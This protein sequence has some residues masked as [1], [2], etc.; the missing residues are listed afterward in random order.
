[1]LILFYI[2]DERKHD[3]RNSIAIG[4]KVR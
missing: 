1:M 2:G 4:G 3:N